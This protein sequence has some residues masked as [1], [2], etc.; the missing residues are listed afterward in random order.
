MTGQFCCLS[1]RVWILGNIS[2]KYR[3]WDK[4]KYG[5]KVDPTTCSISKNWSVL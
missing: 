4:Y 2:P 1:G 5:L 3:N